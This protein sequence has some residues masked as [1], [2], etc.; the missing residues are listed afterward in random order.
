MALGSQ[1]WVQKLHCILLPSN[2]APGLKT[3]PYGSDDGE[4]A[5]SIMSYE[6]PSEPSPYLLLNDQDPLSPAED[7]HLS[8]EQ[9][10]QMSQLSTRIAGYSFR[11]QVERENLS[12]ALSGDIPCC[13]FFL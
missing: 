6:A 10:M 7:L 1:T 2:L 12:Q 5:C 9:M 8:A 11:D 13:G 4:D 3:N